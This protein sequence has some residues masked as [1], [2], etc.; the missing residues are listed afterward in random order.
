MDLKSL[1]TEV[2]GKKPP[3]IVLHGP[4]KIGKS[5][6]GAQAPSPIFLPTEDGLTTINVPAFPKA[7]NLDDFFKYMGLLLTESHDYKTI[8]VDTLDW[9][10]RLIWAKVCDENKVETI[11]NIGYA[12]GYTFAMAHWERFYRGLDKLREKDL[13]PLLLAHNEL[14]TFTPPDNIP[15]DRW[16]IKLHKLAAAKCEEWADAILFANF[17]TYVSKDSKSDK[18]GRAIGGERVIYTSPNPA[19]RAGNRYSLP[20]ELPMDFNILLKHIKGEQ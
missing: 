17:K 13:A 15:Y 8:V 1:I 19:F 4:L 7:E 9:L 6:F 10:E 12:K 11:E 16:Q 20:E 2:R 5:T 14:K 3:R 18:K